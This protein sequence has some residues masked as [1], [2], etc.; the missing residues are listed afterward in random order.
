MSDLKLRLSHITQPMLMVAIAKALSYVAIF[1]PCYYM[2][3]ALM[4][5]DL[6]I[7]VMTGM[8]TEGIHRLTVAAGRMEAALE[9]KA[10]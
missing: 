7:W 3:D 4:D 9:G 6:L 2:C 5:G 10:E 1:V 8:L